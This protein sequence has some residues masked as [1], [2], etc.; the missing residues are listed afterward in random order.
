MIINNKSTQEILSDGDVGTSTKMG[1]D[2]ESHQFLMQMISKFYSDNIG[3][4]IREYVSNCFDSHVAAGKATAPIIVKLFRQNGQWWFSAKDE[5][6]GIDQQL[7]DEVISQYGKSTKRDDNKAIGAF[8]LGMKSGFS[9]SPYFTVTGWKNGK[10]RKWMIREGEK[11]N[12]ID[13]LYEKPSSEKNGAEVLIP[14]NYMN[15]SEWSLKIREQLCYFKNVI[16]TDEH[17]TFNNA[18]KIYENPLFKWSEMCTDNKMHICLSDVYYPIDFKKLGINEIHIPIGIKISLDDGVEPV[19]NREQIKYNGETKKLLIEK[20]E[21]IAEWFVKKYNSE[22]QEFDTFSKALPF[23]GQSTRVVAIQGTSFVINTLVEYTNIPVS[24]VGVKGMMNK[25][26]LH[27][28][29]RYRQLSRKWESV[30]SLDWRKKF[31]TARL[32]WREAYSQSMPVRIVDSVPVGNLRE[33]IKETESA[34]TL[35]IKT[36]GDRRLWEKSSSGIPRNATEN[37]CL[38]Y[39]HILN[40]STFQKSEWRDIIK[41]AQVIEKEY[42]AKFKSLVGLTVPQTWLDARRIANRVKGKYKTLGKDTGEITWGYVRPKANGYGNMVDKRV[43]PVKDL[44]T[45]KQMVVYFSWE[46]K[47]KAIGWSEILKAGNSLHGVCILNTNE[48]KHVKGIHNFKSYKE[49]METKLFKKFATAQL[50]K[51]VV[52]KY[53]PILAACKFD[54]LLKIVADKHLKAYERFTSYITKYDVSMQVD[55]GLEIRQVADKYKLYDLNMLEDIQ[56]VEKQLDKYS[57]VQFLK[58]PDFNAYTKPEEKEAK[59][60][61][62]KNM[63]NNYLLFNKLY[64]NDYEEFDVCLKYKPETLVVEELEENA[65]ETVQV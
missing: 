33:Y 15:V 1:L 64:K 42:E 36:R 56:T 2:P 61:A 25:Y 6:L 29:N 14:I 45:F 50:A 22:V 65:A 38:D 52:E 23:I 21:K 39:Y 5:G 34:D 55:L 12:E 4:P 32:E 46:E 31:S 26:L 47:E 57:F 18:F 54:E 35:F 17:R 62:F 24:E 48:T 28:K 10:E 16:V 20:I 30:A 49:F 3:S 13:P 43:Q 41:Q 59:L 63:I 27:M 8:G 9:Y 19:P 51:I 44:T 40:L 7:I 37:H 60:K 53:K 58:L 11:E